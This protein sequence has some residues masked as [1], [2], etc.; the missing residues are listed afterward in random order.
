MFRKHDCYELGNDKPHVIGLSY[1]SCTFRLRTAAP[2]I[3]P[4]FSRSLQ[5]MDL[6]C[7]SKSSHCEKP[8][9]FPPFLPAVVKSPG[10]PSAVVGSQVTRVDWRYRLSCPCQEGHCFCGSMCVLCWGYCCLKGN[11]LYVGIPRGSLRRLSLLRVAY[12]L[13]LSQHLSSGPSWAPF[14]QG[15]IKRCSVVLMN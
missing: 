15:E 6:S 14:L 12:A 2:Y 9:G 5:R 1:F 10:I 4:D 11:V 8:Y 3:F 13:V 7:V